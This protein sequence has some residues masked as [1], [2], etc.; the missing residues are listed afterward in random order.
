MVHW[1]PL[2]D[3]LDPS[4]SLE[5]STRALFL[6][7]CRSFDDVASS[8]IKAVVGSMA[9]E[10]LRDTK[11]AGDTALRRCEAGSLS[12]DSIVRSRCAEE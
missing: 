12:S 5:L 6:D 1:M 4:P 2:C 8:S 11:R 7:D 10:M 3:Q 9:G